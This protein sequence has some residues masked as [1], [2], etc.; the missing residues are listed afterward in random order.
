MGGI[1]SIALFALM[2]PVMGLGRN[3]AIIALVEKQIR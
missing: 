2:I 1:P 3:T